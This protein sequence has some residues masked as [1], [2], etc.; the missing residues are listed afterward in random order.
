VTGAP[1]GRPMAS[2]RLD[3]AAPRRVHVVGIGGSGM[4]GI[5]T[6]LVGRG[7]VVTGSDLRES[8]VLERLRAQGIDARAGH[9]A[10]NVPAD[11]DAVVVS[12]AI[13]ASN[14]EVVA[15]TARGVP[16]LRRADALGALTATTRT[17]AV[18]GTHGKTTTTAMVALALRGAGWKPSFL[19][20]GDL[21]AL[22]FGAWHD[23]GDWLVVEADESD[24]TFTELAAE[25]VVVT[26]VEADH[27]DHHGSMEA[28]ERGFAR[29]LAEAAGPRLACADDAG[30]MRVA[31]AAGVEVVTYGTDPAADHRIVER[32]PRPG[33]SDVVVELRDGTRVAMALSVPGLHNARNATAALAVAVEL[34]VDATAAAEA[35][36]GFLGVARRFERRGD[37]DGVTLV[38]DYAHLPT[39]LRAALAT[40]REGGWRRVVA[41]FQPHRYSRT[42]A[43]W[44]D[45]GDAF[46]DAD[47]VVLTDV[48]AAGE[49]P[50]PGVSGRLVLQA[51]LDQRPHALVA[52]VSHRADLAAH[53]R[54]LARPGDVVLSLGA[55]DVTALADEW[56]ALDD[57]GAA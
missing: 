4:S 51:V 23:E 19:V 42:E 44:Q 17:I 33:G 12:T 31:R 24:G 28:L 13:P 32:H 2:S 52:Y 20:G 21:P 3:L 48:Y 18:S 34:G 46:D 14:A 11:V 40:A 36:G 10:A 55:G 43:L 49:P 16:V 50:R 53:V 41:V 56:L 26:N 27:L 39:E 45:F 9:A 1:G 35:L 54:G 57:G 5:A 37:V 38:D 47:V 22:G 7:H 30:A 29:F 8:P 25:A 6:L 15:A